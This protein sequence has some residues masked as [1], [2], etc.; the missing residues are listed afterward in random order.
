M[1]IKALKDTADKSIYSFY[2]SQYSF[3]EY[4]STELAALELIDRIHKEIDR[5]QNTIF[6]IY[7]SFGILDVATLYY[8]IT[9]TA[10]N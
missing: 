6:C 7:W 8:G 9:G 3:R 4:H 2:D 1:I 10:L 5:N